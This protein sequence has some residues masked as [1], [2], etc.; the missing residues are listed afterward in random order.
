MTT[1]TKTTVSAAIDA[2]N[3]VASPLDFSFKALAE[4]QG[5]FMSFAVFDL[6]VL[7][8]QF[9]KFPSLTLNEDLSLSL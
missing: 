1:K 9:S 5:L 6:L 2:I 4:L 3:E 8:V 7:R